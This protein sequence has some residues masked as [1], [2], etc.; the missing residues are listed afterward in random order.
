VPFV[1]GTVTGEL[2]ALDVALALGKLGSEPM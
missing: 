1:V 2:K